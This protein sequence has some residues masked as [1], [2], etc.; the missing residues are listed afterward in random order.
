MAR[1]RLHAASRLSLYGLRRR[2]VFGLR[3]VGHRP[4]G[5]DAHRESGP[6]PGRVQG[7]HRGAKVP[8]GKRTLPLDDELVAALTLLRKSQTEESA[9]ARSEGLEPPTF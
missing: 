4:E 5:Q 7:P 6:G 1:D 8:H 9:A 2:E 3:L